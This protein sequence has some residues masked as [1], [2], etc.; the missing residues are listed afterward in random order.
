MVRSDAEPALGVLRVQALGVREGPMKEVSISR[1]EE[2]GHLDVLWRNEARSAHRIV[3]RQALPPPGAQRPD[4]QGPHQASVIAPLVS[5][6]IVR[7]P[8]PRSSVS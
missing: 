1:D 4:E 7:A 3:C 6:T 8:L 5:A 2:L